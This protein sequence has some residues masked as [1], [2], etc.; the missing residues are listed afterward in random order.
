MAKQRRIQARSDIYHANWENAPIRVHD[1]VANM[2]PAQREAVLQKYFKSTN[3]SLRFAAVD[4]KENTKDASFAPMLEAALVDSSSMVRERGLELYPPVD[5][6]RAEKVMLAGL[7]DDDSW[8]RRSAVSTL[9]YQA[10]QDGL[11]DAKA[12]VPYLI[13]ALSDPEYSIPYLAAH[14]LCVITNHTWEVLRRSSPEKQKAVLDKW[15]A[16]WA[17][18]EKTWPVN[19][20]YKD[21]KPIY[22][23][24]KDPAPDFGLRD[25]D[26]NSQNLGS[27]SGK[28]VLLNFWLPESKFSRDD[29]AALQKV[30]DTYKDKGVDV[31]GVALPIVKTQAEARHWIEIY[32]TKYPQCLANDDILSDF[33]G[34]DE[35]ITVL[36]DGDGKLRYRWEG[37]RD[38]ESFQAAVDR[39]LAE[40]AASGQKQ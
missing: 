5:P 34:I 16:W 22:P 21:I 32:K 9:R 24:R 14:V 35:P 38:Y 3:P 28:I 37:D 1:E 10:I 27:E 6:V 33:G 31:I 30:S 25:L 39:L 23:Q 19:P 2:T 18:K 11:P 7:Q 15:R 13:K 26:G 40:K 4:E 8:I 20:V 12:T 29:S 36:I 17:S